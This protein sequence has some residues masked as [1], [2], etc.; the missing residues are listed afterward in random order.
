MEIDRCD[1]SAA[2]RY[3]QSRNMRQPMIWSVTGPQNGRLALHGLGD[4][5]A[6]AAAQRHAGAVPLNVPINSVQSVE[7]CTAG[8]PARETA[9][10]IAPVNAGIARNAP[11]ACKMAK[12]EFAREMGHRPACFRNT[13]TCLRLGGPQTRAKRHANQKQAR[14]QVHDVVSG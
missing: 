9:V 4:N 11:T 6:P 3:A 2:R 5:D 1:K 13:V 10:L 7:P 8:R 14:A 12:P